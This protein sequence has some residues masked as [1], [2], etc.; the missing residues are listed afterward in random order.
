MEGAVDDVL[1]GVFK[2]VSNG[3][4]DGSFNDASSD[5]FNDLFKD[6]V[7]A[8]F[9]DVLLSSFEGLPFLSE[10]TVVLLLSTVTLPQPPPLVI[11][12]N[13]MPAALQTTSLNRH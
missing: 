12:V 9:S 11:L 6:V 5:V 13:S 2:D 4:S 1:K 8:V 10:P 3:A 7:V